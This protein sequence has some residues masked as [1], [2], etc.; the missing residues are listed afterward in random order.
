MIRIT[1]PGKAPGVL[2][3][4]GPKKAAALKG[5]Y[6]KYH[7][8]YESG[9]RVFSFD[10]KT[11]ADESVKQALI[12]A[13]HGKCC[14]CE[15]R[16]T[17]VSYGDIEHFRPKAG[18]RQAAEDDLTRAWLLLV[19]VQLGKLLRSRRWSLPASAPTRM[20]Q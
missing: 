16:I 5:N 7:D 2:A 3:K 17:H 4:N 1:K 9:A 20:C 15:S 12:E 8:Q 6:T 11:Y 10:K 18:H 14:F 19:G 13:R